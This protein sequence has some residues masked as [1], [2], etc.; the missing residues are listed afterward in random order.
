[1]ARH[2][3]HAASSPAVTT[4]SSAADCCSGWSVKPA[5]AHF[6]IANLW[7]L[8]SAVIV[9]ECAAIQFG[10]RGPR[11]FAL[12]LLPPRPKIRSFIRVFFASSSSSESSSPTPSSASPGGSGWTYLRT[13][14]TAWAASRTAC[15]AASAFFCR[16]WTICEL[17][18]KA[19]SNN[20]SIF[21]ARAL[22][23]WE[24]CSAVGESS[25]LCFFRFLPLSS[26]GPSAPS[27]SSRSSLALPSSATIAP[28]CR[29]SFC[30]ASS[31]LCCSAITFCSTKLASSALL[32][33]SA[34]CSSSFTTASGGLAF[35]APGSVGKRSRPACRLNLSFRAA[36]IAAPGG[37]C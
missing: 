13:T 1:M 9:V 32:A 5:A 17:L 7:P 35:F 8:E 31:N 27:A 25:S 4:W 16:F 28:R 30:R 6:C 14:A 20:P 2:R 21:F 37:V 23:S 12:L 10:C 33:S 26:S 18:A 34:R 24:G 19:W 15:S 22:S 29:A 36:W 3:R 11:F